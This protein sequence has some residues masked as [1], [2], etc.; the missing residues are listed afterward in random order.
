E[1]VAESPTV[2]L[3]GAHNVQKAAS[4]A[5]ALGNLRPA[6]NGRTVLIFGSLESKHPDQMLRLLTP[7]FDRLILTAPVASGKVDAHPAKLADELA[8][9][10]YAGEIT[11]ETDPQAAMSMALGEARPNDLIVVTGSLYLIGN[12]RERW[13]STRAIVEQQT[14][15]PE[16][17][18]R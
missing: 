6:V 11:V 12:I 1:I 16:A 18:M 15:W 3:D 8:E 14:P 9:E 17:G 7:Q 10:G 5:E 2:L 13:F 4:L